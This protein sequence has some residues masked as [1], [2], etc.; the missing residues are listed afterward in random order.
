MGGPSAFVAVGN[1]WRSHP[2]ETDTWLVEFVVGMGTSK[3]KL[4]VVVE[5]GPYVG[6]NMLKVA[7]NRLRIFCAALADATTIHALTDDQIRKLRVDYEPDA[8]KR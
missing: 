6:E 8:L 5:R 1:V 4:T 2:G 7:R 3:G